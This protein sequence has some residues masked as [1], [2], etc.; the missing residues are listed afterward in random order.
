MSLTVLSESKMYGGI[1]RRYKHQSSSCGCPMNFTIYFPPSTA[2]SPV[3]Y[4]LSGLTCTDENVIIKSNIQRKASELGIAIVAPDTS[5]RG[6]EIEGESDSYDFGVGAGFYLNATQEKW[7]NWRM[8][9]YV[10][11]ELPNIL[12][13]NVPQIDTQNASITGHSMGGHGALTLG[14]K[15]ASQ[16]KSISAFAP[17]CNPI[18]VP[19]GQK[20]FAGYLGEDKSQWLQY[21]ASE[22]IK[23]VSEKVVILV[24]QGT[25]DNFLKEQLQPEVL[26]AAAKENQNVT[27]ELRMQ[28]GYDHSYFFISTFIDDHL[29]FH[30]KYLQIS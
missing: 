17:I 5:P 4:Y 18:N 12:A 2:K 15:N 16:Y 6:L 1:N 8:Y 14:M 13:Q 25:E 26:E 30:A 23:N 3:L 19:W 10:V 28:Q 11:D 22:I 9:D 27:L 7:K 24:D 29:N 20:A 21:D